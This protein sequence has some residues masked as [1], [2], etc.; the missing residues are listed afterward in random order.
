MTPALAVRRPS[1]TRAAVVVALI[2]AVLGGCSGSDDDADDSTR[3][4]L[5]NLPIISGGD[6]HDEIGASDNGRWWVIARYETDRVVRVDT[7]TG[8]VRPMPGLR[9]ES[10]NPYEVTDSG[11]VEA[12]ASRA[13][14]PDVPLDRT[15]AGARLYAVTSSVFLSSAG[16]AGRKV[17]EGFPQRG[18]ELAGPS[19]DGTISES[20]HVVTVRT[21]HGYDPADRNHAVDVYQLDLRSGR[22]TWVS[23]TYAPG[24][25]GV[26]ASANGRFVV[27]DGTLRAGTADGGRAPVALRWDRRTDTTV[28]MSLTDKGRP[29]RRG[30]T[31]QFSV[32]NGGR[33]AFVSY[34]CN[35]T[36]AKP[37]RGAASCLYLS[38]PA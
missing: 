17:A 19:S 5:V 1:W 13:S 34:D 31:G 38:V 14:Y 35:L 16:G 8:T 21:T 37:P 12:D 6:E 22:R 3:L 2:G 25:G 18:P 32:T 10:G 36:A 15:D 20:G 26:T 30:V 9:H 7:R 11:R 4:R 24:G 27:F 23:R 28:V 29:G 33:V